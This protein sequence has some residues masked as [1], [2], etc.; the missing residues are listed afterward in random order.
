[1]EDDNEPRAEGWN[2]RRRRRMGRKRKKS[3]LKGSK[4]IGNDFESRNCRSLKEGC[5][6]VLFYFAVM[7]ERNK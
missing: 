1:M 5:L 3:I 2:E 4:S 6:L 7:N